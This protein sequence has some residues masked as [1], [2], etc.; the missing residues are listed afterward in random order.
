MDIEK[1]QHSV[2]LVQSAAD[3]GVLS[4]VAREGLGVRSTGHQIEYIIKKSYVPQKPTNLLLVTLQPDDSWSIFEPMRSNQNHIM[5]GHN[6]LIDMMARTPQGR[7]TLLQT[8][9]L[10]GRLINPFKPLH[11]CDKLN[12]GNYTFSD[13]GT[14]LYEET[15]VTLGTVLVKAEELIRQG[16][17]VRTATL[18][19]SDGEPTPR[20]LTPLKQE[21]L[22]TLVADMRRGRGDHIIAAMGV[23]Y[24][25]Q[26]RKTFIE[27]GLD[28]QHIF[29]A[30]SREEILKAFRL[31]GEQALQMLT[32]GSTHP[33][34]RK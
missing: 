11:L 28:P 23:G 31:F 6:D 2:D 26:Y 29:S 15:F 21:R 18:I 12:D 9:F 34:T 1:W 17:H 16:C 30:E 14:P 27:M 20:D 33:A 10:N 24:K 22:R 4:P 25:D 32:Q 19:M 5:E 8:R 13:S 7:R 3:R